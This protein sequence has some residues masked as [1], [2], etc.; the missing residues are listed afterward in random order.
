MGFMDGMKNWFVNAMDLQKKE[1]GGWGLTPDYMSF[2]NT[3]WG[4]LQPVSY[5][6]LWKAYLEDPIVH[7]CINRLAEAVVGDGY[8]LVGGSRLHRKKISDLFKNNEFTINLQDI[9]LSLLIYGDAYLEIIREEKDNAL[10]HSIDNLESEIKK[11]NCDEDLCKS[12]NLYSEEIKNRG[13][14]TDL[15]IYKQI[16]KNNN[17]Y[18]LMSQFYPRDARTIRID[19]NEHGE[20]IKYIQRVLHRRVDFYPDEMIHFR[21]NVI[22]NRQYGHSAM[23]SIL[24]TLQAKIAAENYNAD[25]FRR[26][27]IPRMFYNVKNLSEEQ[28]KRLRSNLQLLQPQQ[29]VIMVG[30]VEAK[31]LAPTNQDIQFREL[32]GYYRENI[33]AALGVPS[34]FLGLETKAGRNTSQTRMEAFDR[35][36]RALRSAIADK[37]NNQ[38]LTKENLGF[39]DVI[40]EF[41]DENNREELKDAQVAGLLAPLIQTGVVTPD[42]I[43]IKLKLPPMSDIDQ[44]NGSQWGSSERLSPHPG[45]HPSLLPPESDSRRSPERN[46]GREQQNV[47]QQIENKTIMKNKMRNSPTGKIDWIMAPRGREN[48][49]PITSY[50]VQFTPTGQRIKTPIGTNVSHG[51]GET[52]YPFGAVP[53]VQEPEKE[54]LE[55]QESDKIRDIRDVAQNPISNAEGLNTQRVWPKDKIIVPETR[56]RRTRKPPSKEDIDARDPRKHPERDEIDQYGVP[57]WV[58]PDSRYSDVTVGSPFHDVQRR[59]EM[60]YSMEENI[61]FEKSKPKLTT[62]FKREHKKEYDK[63]RKEHPDFTTA[64]VWQVVWDHA[65][66]KKFVFYKGT[67]QVEDENIKIDKK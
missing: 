3:Y 35:R 16:Q 32:L 12:A 48:Q 50:A 43:R 63:E 58:A 53:I 62:E 30:D 8:K 31:S 47:D 40:F 42:E 25:Y 64:Q 59:G 29:D 26:G 23:Q 20:V 5:A 54:Q 36:V 39:D 60:R 24:S 49:G 17:D 55:R 67:S 28:V 6:L 66:K 1:A 9:V 41:V 21:L 61:D 52:R 38:L 22:G 11:R 2:R 46:E 14:Y 44:V 19:Y 37:I 18:G 34:E 51:T 57:R 7:A 13:S 4:Q 27:A 33:I 56:Q 65:T 45:V 15:D 10:Y